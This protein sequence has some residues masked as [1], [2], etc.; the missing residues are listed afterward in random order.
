MRFYEI[1]GCKG[2]LEGLDAFRFFLNTDVPAA[3]TEK[4]QDKKKS[5][6]NSRQAARSNPFM[7]KEA[8]GGGKS[9][10]LVPLLRYADCGTQSKSRGSGLWRPYLIYCNLILALLSC[11][12]TSINWSW[13]VHVLH[14]SSVSPST[15]DRRHFLSNGNFPKYSR[16]VRVDREE[17]YFLILT[18]KNI[19]GFKN[20]LY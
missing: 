1:L 13:H 9:R 20:F 5:R 19:Y 17:H 11:R 7:S 3:I 14:N 8:P 15:Q 4:I 6:L 12:R 10:Y 2:G 16:V 18:W